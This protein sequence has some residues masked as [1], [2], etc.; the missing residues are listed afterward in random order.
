MQVGMKFKARQVDSMIDTIH[1]HTLSLC[2][3]VCMSTHACVL[4]DQVLDAY[5]SSL[6]CF[7]CNRGDGEDCLMLCDGC[8]S[9]WHTF[10]LTP[11][12]PE[13]PEGAWFCGACIP[14]RKRRG[15]KGEVGAVSRRGGRKSKDGTG[16][17]ARKRDEQPLTPLSSPTLS[18]KKKAKRDKGRTVGAIGCCSRQSPN[19]AATLE[20]EGVARKARLSPDEQATTTTT[21]TKPKR[22]LQIQTANV[23]SNIAAAAAATVS[24]DTT[25][26]ST[27]TVTTTTTTTTTTTEE[28]AAAANTTIQTR[29]QVLA[30]ATP[31]PYTGKLW[32][33]ERAELM[34]AQRALVSV[35]EMKQILYSTWSMDPMDEFSALRYAISVFQTANY[36]RAMYRVVVPI[37]YRNYQPNGTCAYMDL[38]ACIGFWHPHDKHY[39]E[40]G[41]THDTYVNLL[42]AVCQLYGSDCIEAGSGPTEKDPREDEMQ[43]GSARGKRKSV[44]KAGVVSKRRRRTSGGD[45]GKQ[46]HTERQQV[47]VEAGRPMERKDDEDDE[48]FQY[49]SV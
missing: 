3:S 11:A 6:K 40:W 45:D 1:T 20:V 47:E 4:V 27:V 32:F 29:A 25:S 38:F 44:G 30:E 18:I 16:R 42:E 5:M 36:R 48:E 31:K 26:T 33:T 41:A 13:V 15:N 39:H 35:E 34:V 22:R 8:N 43:S 17:R 49:K 9:A 14:D 23:K 10:C 19:G 46:R 2:L 28:E 37:A 24:N 7:K 12:L 21:P